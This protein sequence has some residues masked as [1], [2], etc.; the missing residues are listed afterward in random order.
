MFCCYLYFNFILQ[1]N[2]YSILI[3]VSSAQEIAV[4]IGCIRL[5][6]TP[7]DYYLL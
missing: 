1:V 7:S 3:K 2:K 4:V 6:I 5:I